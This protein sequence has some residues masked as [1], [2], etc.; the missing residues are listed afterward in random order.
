M[1]QSR[2]GSLR[3]SLIN[4]GIG[5]GVSLAAQMIFLP[6]LG[7]SIDHAQNFVFACIM[8][9]VSV[10]R[11]YLVRR[12][13]EALHIRVP[14]SPFMQAVIAERRRQIDVE[15]W[16]ASHDDEYAQ[17][18]LARAG[19]CYALSCAEPLNVAA[20]RRKNVRSMEAVDLWAWDR[21]WWKPADFRRNLVKAGALLLAEGEKFDRLKT[22]RR[23]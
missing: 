9:V 14:M 21:A 11:T 20:N 16:S 23:A 10:T 15:G 4:V 8:T 22:R 5:F 1:K 19:A 12:L 3:E 7:V 13:F 6:L 2:L 17:G 18:D